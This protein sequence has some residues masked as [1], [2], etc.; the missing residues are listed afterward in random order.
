MFPD[1]QLAPDTSN[2]HD[3]MDVYLGR[4]DF[5]ISQV[6]YGPIASP[7]WQQCLPLSQAADMQHSVSARW[8]RVPRAPLPDGTSTSTNVG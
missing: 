1:R 6:R 5:E 8:T 3:A 2:P 7:W 4:L